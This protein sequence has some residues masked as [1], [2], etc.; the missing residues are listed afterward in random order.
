MI[1]KRVIR[2]LNSGNVESASDS[3]KCSLPNYQVLPF[4]NHQTNGFRNKLSSLFKFG[5]E[6]KR[7]KLD[8]ISG[9]VAGI[10]KLSVDC[11]SALK[12]AKAT[13]KAAKSF[14][15][16][17][18]KGSNSAIDDVMQKV[19]QVMQLHADSQ[20]QFAK[21]YELCLQK[22]QKVGQTEL[23]MKETV[24]KLNKVRAHERQLQKKIR[25]LMANE[26]DTVL[27]RRQ[28]DQAILARESAEKNL[29]KEE[30][31]QKWSKCS[32][33]GRQ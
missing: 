12:S 33:S 10:D 3:P 19:S 1:H 27:L 22:L 6:E 25:K 16:W 31:K 5:R 29:A 13:K 11:K 24:K 7:E 26:E 21:D 2:K 4:P 23:R 9:L 14:A 30:L 17:A 15:K 8:D 20:A 32:S 28:L 18:E